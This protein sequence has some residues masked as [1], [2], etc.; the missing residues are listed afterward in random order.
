MQQSMPICAIPVDKNEQIA[1]GGNVSAR[2]ELSQCQARAPSTRTMRGSCPRSSVLHER[3]HLVTRLPARSMSSIRRWMTPADPAPRQRGNR[4]VPVRPARTQL[5]PVRTPQQRLNRGGDR[6]DARRLRSRIRQM[7]AWQACLTWQFDFA[8]YA[9]A[10]AL[11]DAT[12]LRAAAPLADADC[13]RWIRQGDLAKARAV[14]TK[15]AM[16]S[17]RDESRKRPA[18]TSHRGG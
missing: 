2:V 15:W 14:A 7:V 5:R 17:N 13:W 16:T 18:K 11:D 3:P 1:R 6:A 12:D 10:L 4:S 9:I 8:D